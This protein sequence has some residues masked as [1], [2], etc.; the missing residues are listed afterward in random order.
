MAR[1]IAAISSGVEGR[2]LAMSV[3][4][5]TALVG[6]TMIAAPSAHAMS[7]NDLLTL[8]LSRDDAAGSY[9]LGYIGG[10]V[11]TSPLICA[12]AEAAR[13]QGRDIVVQYLESHPERRQLAAPILALGALKQAW[14]CR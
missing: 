3:F 2:K 12:P 14:P 5:Y 1:S 6:A 11:E 4:L 8:C 9:C 10:I 13:S 7:G